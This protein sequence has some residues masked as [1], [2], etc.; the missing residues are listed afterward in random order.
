M[1]KSRQENNV[2]MVGFLK[3]DNFV[4]TLSAEGWNFIE[5]NAQNAGNR[6]EHE[7]LEAVVVNFGKLKKVCNLYNEIAK[8][9]NPPSIIIAVENGKLDSVVQLVREKGIEYIVKPF[10]AMELVFRIERLQELEKARRA[11]ELYKR[12]RELFST[13]AL[14]KLMSTIIDHAAR[15]LHADEASIML[16]DDREKK[17]C[18]VASTT[19]DKEFKGRSVPIAASVGGKV[20]S[21][22][23]PAII[24]GRI[25][26]SG[27]TGKRRRIHSSI[28]YPLIY[29]N[30]IMGILN[31][32]RIKGKEKFVPYDLETTGAFCRDIT[33]A[34]SNL[35]THQKTDVKAIIKMAEQATLL[36]K[37]Q[38]EDHLDT[39]TGIS[40]IRK[41]QAMKK[42]LNVVHRIAATD[43]TVLLQGET[44]VGKEVI[45]RF[46]HASSAC[47]HKPFVVV[48]CGALPESL[49]ESELFGFERG[50]FTGALYKKEGLFEIASDG[51]IFLD[52]IGNLPPVVQ[53]KLLRVLDTKK[54]THIG[55]KRVIAAN[56]RVIAASNMDLREAVSQG[57]F[58]MDLYQRLSQF[59]VTIPPLRER[60]ADIIPLAEYFIEEIRKEL[61]RRAL[62]LSPNGREILLNYNW[63][64][65]VRELRNAIRRG[66]FST[67]SEVLPERLHVVNHIVTRLGKITMPVG[68][69]FEMEKRLILDAL[70]RTNNNKKNAA[71]L[72]RISRSTLYNKLKKYG[73][74]V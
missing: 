20:I 63:P 40:I 5:E 43:L 60:K 61:N 47:N 36:D 11:A 4:Y 23:K 35:M 39:S 50:A 3:E 68:G 62:H 38:K 67:D 18:L 13:L 10:E 16:F 28:V 27:D 53:T 65:N 15:F 55:G 49:A 1:A 12:S 14:D 58:R 59:V 73:I 48:D 69:D 33:Q 56:A 34:L 52:E 71:R 25:N 17:I 51:T 22:R 26:V 64:G 37:S 46:I 72:L 29:K 57:R 74:P 7:R 8:R 21:T 41:S 19:L 2:M 6:L 30:S 44:G 9:H 32:N 70:E 42:I 24:H 45:A 66:A 31:I 54:I